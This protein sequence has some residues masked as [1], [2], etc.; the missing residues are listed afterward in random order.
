[1]QRLE[2]HRRPN[3]FILDNQKR[4][5]I[6]LNFHNYVFFPFNESDYFA[7][8]IPKPKVRSE[9]ILKHLSNCLFYIFDV[10][11]EFCCCYIANNTIKTSTFKAAKKNVHFY[12]VGFFWWECDF[13]LSKCAD[14]TSGEN[15][16]THNHSPNVCM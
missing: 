8:Y 13:K 10:I 15:G 1:M 9:Q 5:N 16:F 4:S 12:V 3:Y 2:K 14:K 7:F 11:R 6:E